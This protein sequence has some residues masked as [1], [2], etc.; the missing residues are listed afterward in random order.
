MDRIRT[1]WTRLARSPRRLALTAAIA[2]VAV[3]GGVGFAIAVNGIR[4][5]SGTG[6]SPSAVAA[7]DTSPSEDASPTP[8]P[9]QTPSLA[10]SPTASPTASPTP[11]PA[12]TPVPSLTPAPTATPTPTPQPA[13]A[14]GAC[15]DFAF[16]PAAVISVD[17]LA[18]L[19]EGMVGTWV[20]CVTTPWV[21]RY[22]VTI[23]FRADGTYS[24][25]AEEAAGEP[26]FYYGT[27]D[28]MSEKRYELNDLQDDLE[29]V[30]QID[31]VF[32]EGNTN[33]GELRNIRLTGNELE[34]EFFHRG[35]YGPLLYQLYRVAPS[36]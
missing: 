21:P 5:A 9:T 36:N 29:G 11:S 33:R 17:S 10:P 32:W 22:W 23:T 26:A 14:Q 7:L 20:G 13:P 18:E 3:V 15:D 12:A 2:A 34:F 4:Q 25:F 16:T 24:G 6:A 8:T 35:E 19:E 1:A 30:G 27:D 28:D 31:I